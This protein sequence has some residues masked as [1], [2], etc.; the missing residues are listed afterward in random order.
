[1][2]LLFA[3]FLVISF[4]LE[5]ILASFALGGSLGYVTAVTIHTIDHARDETKNRKRNRNLICTFA[6]EGKLAWLKKA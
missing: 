2:S 3:L 4:F 6:F 1:V 5:T